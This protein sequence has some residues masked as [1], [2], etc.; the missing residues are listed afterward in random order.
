MEPR[1]SVLALVLLVVACAV[2]SVAPAQSLKSALVGSWSLAAVEDRYDSG[3]KVNNWGTPKGNLT[4]DPSGRFSQ[5]IVGD[6]QPA[7]KGPDPRKPDAP[8]VAYY[9]TYT[10]DEATK[11][12]TFKL[13]AASYSPRAGTSLSSNV[14]IKGNVMTLV[15][16]PRK[17]QIG[18]FRPQLQLRRATG[19]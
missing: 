8:V 15:G 4:F 16:A 17:D 5:I 2:P 10:V 1:N 7:L 18:T 19:L 3:Q 13:E 14:D 6:V 11:T 9:G 12:V